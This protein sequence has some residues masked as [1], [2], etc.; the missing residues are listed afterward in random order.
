MPTLNG[1]GGHHA[2]DLKAI[3]P[4]LFPDPADRF[5]LRGLR[6]ATSIT[7]LSFNANI[8]GRLRLGRR[9]RAPS[10]IHRFCSSWSTMFETVLGGR[11]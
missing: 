6:S 11:R 2:W 8:V 4:T 9:A 7:R 1:D 10:T 3:D 5:A